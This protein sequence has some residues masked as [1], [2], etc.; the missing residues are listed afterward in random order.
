MTLKVSRV[1]LLAMAAVV[2]LA[3]TGWA[4]TLQMKDGRQING[5]FLGATKS[6]I[7]FKEEGNTKIEHFRISD[8]Q[9]LT[10][11]GAT[12]PAG[13]QGMMTIPPA[14]S[15]PSANPQTRSQP[16]STTASETSA[17]NTITVPAGTRIVARMVDSVNSDINKVGDRFHCV[18][19]ED[20]AVNGTTVAAKGSDCYGRLVQSSA[21]PS[22]SESSSTYG[23][24]SASKPLTLEL[25]EIDINGQPRVITNSNVPQTQMEPQAEET[26]VPTN[27]ALATAVLRSPTPAGGMQPTAGVASGAAGATQVMI[28][29]NRVFVP[30]D[31]VLEFHLQAPWVINLQSPSR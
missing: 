21:T 12:A 11:S 16:P 2:A 30:S 31:T 24:E 10:F 8:V 28:N 1:F 13:Q 5:T 7:R 19:D 27:G 18:L 4:D 9:A 14:G 22:T 20:L 17:M 25:T 23:S 26:A 6:T 3:L 29:G 15:Q